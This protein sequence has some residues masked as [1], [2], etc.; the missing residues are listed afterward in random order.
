MEADRLAKGWNYT[1]L[2]SEAGVNLTTV[3]RFFAGTHQ[4][5]ATAK[6]VALALGYPVLRYLKDAKQAVA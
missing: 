6:K 1:A 4:S 2:A 3:T 5:P